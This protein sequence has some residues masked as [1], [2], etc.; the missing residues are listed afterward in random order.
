MRPIGRFPLAVL[1]QALPVAQPPSPA[2]G[3]I[4]SIWWR[5]D[6]WSLTSANR[7]VIVMGVGANV[8]PMPMNDANLKRRIAAVAADS[9]NVQFTAHARTRMRERRVIASQ[10][11][12]ALC[13]GFVSEGAHQNIYGNWQC[14]LERVVAGDRIRV[15]AALVEHD[16]E[17]VVV[18]TVMR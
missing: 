12:E 13:K 16:G 18:V 6:Q 14:T 11:I 3:G 1:A 7:P 8:L 5:L 2:A 10:V 15:A 17:S 4:V 9:A